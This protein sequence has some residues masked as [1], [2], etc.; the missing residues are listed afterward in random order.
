[1]A[2]IDRSSPII[3]G[4]YEAPVKQEEMD[5]DLN[6]EN[7]PILSRSNAPSPSIHLG[8]YKL[9]DPL[10]LDNLAQHNQPTWDDSYEMVTDHDL[11]H[12]NPGGH[13]HCCRSDEQAH[14]SSHSALSSILG[15][16]DKENFPP[17]RKMCFLRY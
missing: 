8:K 4:G 12:P 17:E 10:T 16:S 15:H 13:C 3:D 14:H 9:S 11:K 6:E 2:I 7:F 5:I 1:M